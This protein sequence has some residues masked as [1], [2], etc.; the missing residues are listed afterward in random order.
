MK[1]PGPTLTLTPAKAKRL[2]FIAEYF[3]PQTPLI[4]SNI[5]RS[6]QPHIPPPRLA[7]N[8]KPSLAGYLIRAGNEPSADATSDATS[9]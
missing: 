2:T 1:Q 6:L 7:Y 8:T 4:A 9:T 5:L 3:S